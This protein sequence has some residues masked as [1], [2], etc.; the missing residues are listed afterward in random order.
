MSKKMPF[1]DLRFRGTWWYLAEEVD[2]K[3][4]AINDWL[5]TDPVSYSK[6]GS[7][8]KS[9]LEEWKAEGLKILEAS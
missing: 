8:T 5:E 9:C 3:L 1:S 2:Q 7:I 4:E 6:R